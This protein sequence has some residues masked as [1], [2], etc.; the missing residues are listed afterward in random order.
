MA[1]PVTDGRPARIAPMDASTAPPRARRRRPA[2][3]APCRPWS[4]W[5]ASVVIGGAVWPCAV[6]ERP[7]PPHRHRRRRR[8]R[9]RCRRSDPPSTGYLVARPTWPIGRR[10]RRRALNR[11]RLRAWIW[12]PTRTRALE[13][14]ASPDG[15]PRHPGDRGPVRRRHGERVRAR[16]GVRRHRATPATPRARATTSWPGS[17]R[18]RPWS[19][20]ARRTVAARRR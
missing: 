2:G 3:A 8:R 4:C 9:P 11:S 6:A 7:P 16:P 18:P 20:R 15:Q 13:T 10:S 12:S 17:T 1:G 5:S 14:S 19:T